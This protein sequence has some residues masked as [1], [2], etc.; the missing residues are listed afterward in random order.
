MP[1]PEVF[2][3]LDA[4]V[5][6]LQMMAKAVEVLRNTCDT[7][8]LPTNANLTLPNGTVLALILFLS[9]QR[10]K[11]LTNLPL[12]M[13]ISRIITLRGKLQSWI[14]S[15]LVMPTLTFPRVPSNF[16]IPMRMHLLL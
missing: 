2:F 6:I 3:A 4:I 16:L 5:V 7:A 9:C 15:L 1:C 8:K 14:I 13:L 12:T 11:E 10:N